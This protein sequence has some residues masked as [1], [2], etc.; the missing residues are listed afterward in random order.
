MNPQ[1]R[2]RLVGYTRHMGSFF[3]GV[4]FV[5]VAQAVAQTTATQ[6]DIQAN[7]IDSENCLETGPPLLRYKKEALDRRE[8]E[9]TKKEK[10]LV[11]AR[12]GLNK[13]FTQLEEIRDELDQKMKEMDQR[14][15]EK[16][17][18]LVARFSKIRAKQAAAILE[19]TEDDVSVAVLQKMEPSKSGKILAAMQ[20]ERAALLTEILARH[21]LR[22]D[23]EA[24]RERQ[25]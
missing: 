22:S 20:V 24:E 16:I 12:E 17:E 10:D 7:N 4:I 6:Q 8:R 2:K 9:I 21:P 15:A 25:T 19:K 1:N 23:E 18:A 13:Q 3:I 14:K 11:K 5:I